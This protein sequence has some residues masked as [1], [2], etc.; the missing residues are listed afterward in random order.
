MEAWIKEIEMENKSIAGT[1][2]TNE[3]VDCLCEIYVDVKKAMDDGK[4]NFDDIP[5]FYPL[6]AKL[7]KAVDK[8]NQVPAELRDLDSTEGQALLTLVASKLGLADQTEKV[9][10]IVEG[11]FQV[12]LGGLK[13]VSALR[14]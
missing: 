12:V 3:L 5:H 4:L 6:L 14:A 8:I 10:G 11:V 2:E 7:P 1:P 9:R 13:I